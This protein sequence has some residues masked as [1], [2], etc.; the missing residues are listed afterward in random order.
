ML[1][2]FTGLC[3]GPPYAAVEPSLLCPPDEPGGAVLP[4]HLLVSLAHQEGRDAV[5]P[6]AGKK[7]SHS[8]REKKPVPC[9][10]QIES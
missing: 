8:Q 4:L 6:T 10:S 3:E 2:F 5:R 1:F 9:L 7:P